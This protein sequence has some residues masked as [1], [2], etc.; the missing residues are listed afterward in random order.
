[1][2]NWP[3]IFPG[4]FCNI[5]KTSFSELAPYEQ[6]GQLRAVYAGPITQHAIDQLTILESVESIKKKIYNGATH[7]AF[8]D[9]DEALYWTRIYS[10]HSI[11]K[12]LR[13][14]LPKGRFLCTTHP[15]ATI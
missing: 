9:K 14:I 12:R 2:T 3:Y 10:C 11:I 4:L 1:M 6:S 5:L 13:H 15:F 7:I 8:D